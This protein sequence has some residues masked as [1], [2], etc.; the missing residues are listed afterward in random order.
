[1]ALPDLLTMSTRFSSGQQGK[2]QGKAATSTASTILSWFKL[3]GPWL[4]GYGV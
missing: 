1:M 3:D 2:T 4:T